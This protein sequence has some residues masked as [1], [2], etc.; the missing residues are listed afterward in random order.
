MV[1]SGGCSKPGAERLGASATHP[2]AAPP[3][4]PLL[5]PAG[6]LRPSLLWFPGP[7]LAGIT[8]ATTDLLANFGAI[9][10]GALFLAPRLPLVSQ[11]VAAALVPQVRVQGGV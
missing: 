5:P 3:L 6:K 2:L 10:Q 7:T 1:S 4:L 9:P 8:T 11:A